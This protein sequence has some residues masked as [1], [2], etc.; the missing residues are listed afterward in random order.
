MT[1]PNL[2]KDEEITLLRSLI[3]DREL[4]IAQQKEDIKELRARLNEYQLNESPAT[5][6]DELD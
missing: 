5:N 2:Y 3:A 6:T 4:V 1:D